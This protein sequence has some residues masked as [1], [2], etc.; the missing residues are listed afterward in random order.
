M[1]GRGCCVAAVDR[2]QSMSCWMCSVKFG[3]LSSKIVNRH[4]CQLS[5]QAVS[6]QQVNKD[7]TITLTKKEINQI[8]Y[9]Y[10]CMMVAKLM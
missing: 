3:L 8:I 7:D 4:S 6:V 9:R 1:R 2:P 10:M 5:Q